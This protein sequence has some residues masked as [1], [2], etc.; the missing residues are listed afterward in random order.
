MK[1]ILITQRHSQDRHGAW[2][3][4]LENS[5]TSFFSS[6]G[7]NLFP[8][9]NVQA[10]AREYA[11]Y[12]QPAGIILT[13]GGDVDPALYEASINNESLPISPE[14][15][16]IEG[17][18]I[19]YAL[20]ANIPILGICRGMQFINVHFG[21]KLT[22]DLQA[23]DPGQ[24][25]KTPGPHEITIT[26]ENLANQMNTGE[27]KLEVNSYHN[28]GILETMLADTLRSF[29]IFEE[30]SLIEGLYHPTKPII[31]IQWHPEREKTILPLDKLLIEKFLNAEII[32]NR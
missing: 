7:L 9:S 2:I 24:L 13:G 5:Y 23:H 3:D 10:N 15:D 16:A 22:R 29:A 6:F 1:N 26:N 27:R 4:S 12:L 20:Q 21:G 32:D 11:R 19:D 14:R 30:L 8:V 28:H 25:H 31:G 17:Q 18:L